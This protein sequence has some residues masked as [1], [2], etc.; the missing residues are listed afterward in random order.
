MSTE[1]D[2]KPGKDKLAI[3]VA[4][5]DIF[6]DGVVGAMVR[7]GVVRIN[8]VNTR[9]DAHDGAAEHAMVARMFMS[10]SGVHNLHA[11][12]EKVLGQLQRSGDR[13]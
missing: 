7:D 6:V 9:F 12:L 13:E 11:A 8:L 2:P 5:P 4:C 3:D 1:E 10:R